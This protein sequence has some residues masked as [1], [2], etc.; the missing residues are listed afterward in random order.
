MREIRSL[1]LAATLLGAAT[2]A[3]GALA[4]EEPG[5]RKPQTIEVEPVPE[6]V[7]RDPDFVVRAA[8]TSGLPVTFTASGDCSVTRATVHLLSAG[9]CF[10]TAR[11][12]GD[13]A[14]EPAEEVNVRIRV[15][16][17]AQEIRFPQPPERK[18][19]DPAF[20]PEARATSG[21]PLTFF[22]SGDC[23]VSGSVVTILAAGSCALT[24]HQPGNE[25]FTAAR[26]VD[27]QFDILR[28]DQTIDFA[29]LSDQQLE[30]A[31]DIV[32]TA[33]ASSSLPVHFYVEGPCALQGNVLR[34][35]GAG[36]CRVTAGQVGNANF[37]PAPPV[38][39]SF[40]V[41]SNG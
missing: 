14:F 20:V 6:K 26:I 18:Y 2:L 1:A 7:F 10:V 40:T 30:T 22:A 37:N 41:W 12:E 21:L 24:A 15:A 27:R 13:E 9:T 29:P 36:F 25:N 23:K 31:I 33:S 5:G 38:Q 19:L 8:A 28:A 32:L 4:A 16:K 11:Q 39:R 35:L 34:V 17:A 3:P